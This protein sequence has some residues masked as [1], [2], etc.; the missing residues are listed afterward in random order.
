M[1]SITSNPNITCDFTPPEVSLWA[2]NSRYTGEALPSILD[3][4]MPIKALREAVSQPSLAEQELLDELERDAITAIASSVKECVRFVPDVR[5]WEERASGDC[6]TFTWLISDIVE[7][8]GLT[9]RIAFCN[10]HAFNLIKGPAGKVHMINGES[11]HMWLFDIANNQATRLAFGDD[12]GDAFDHAEHESSIARSLFT[13]SLNYYS[14]SENP[15][16]VLAWLHDHNPAMAI[17]TAEY[18][19]RALFVYSCFKA[20]LKSGNAKELKVTMDELDEFN[21]ELETRTKKNPVLNDF[22]KAVGAMARRNDIDSETVIGIVEQFAKIMPHT[23][24]MAV[25]A[26][27]CLRSVGKSQRDSEVLGQAEQHYYEAA[28]LGNKGLHQDKT[29]AGK[30]AKTKKE[31]SSLSEPDPVCA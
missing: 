1:E 21:P 28:R 12:I 9:S 20:A 14:K 23:K 8:M 16:I 30:I 29:L 17:M 15:Q 31:L 24:S 26:G 18:G 19:K 7:D 5:P 4:S 3:S 2:F 25:I 22:K 6:Y 27:D 13:D 11:P 10:G